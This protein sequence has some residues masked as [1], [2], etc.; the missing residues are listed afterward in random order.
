M[1]RYFVAAFC[2]AA[3]LFSSLAQ[4]QPGLSV[5]YESA[6]E[7]SAR[8]AREALQNSEAITALVNG[9]NRDFRLEVPVEVIFGAE[10]GPLYD[11][12]Q[13]QIWMPYQFDSDVRQRFAEDDYVYLDDRLQAELAIRR[14]ELIVAYPTA[15]KPASPFSNPLV[16]I[17][18]G[19][20][21]IIFL[22]NVMNNSSSDR[23]PERSDPS[24]VR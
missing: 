16:L 1:I 7:A 4:A 2:A 5:R 6:I 9:L 17:A 10:D 3:L 21:A 20:M 23:L 19:F 8:V 14:A 13:R 24:S 12:E 22:G 15:P 18:L 11:S